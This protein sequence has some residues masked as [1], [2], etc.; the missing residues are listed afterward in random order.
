M[1]IV[2]VEDTRNIEWRANNKGSAL[3]QKM[4]WSEGKGI[5]KRNANTTALRAVKRQE[6]LGLGAKLE[7]EGGQSE[8][9]NTFAAVLKTLQQHHGTNE[10]T[11]KKKNKKE[12][13]KKS[14]REK[15][16]KGMVLPSNKVTAG[17]AQ[18]MRLAKFGEKNVDDLACIFGNKDIAAALRP[19][20]IA[21]VVSAQVSETSSNL[22]SV[23]ETEKKKD[24]K[25]KKRSRESEPREDVH[26]PVERGETVEVERKKRRKDNK[27]EKKAKKKSRA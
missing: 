18:K 15:K 12:E 26:T 2:Q 1:T 6:G 4:G 20:V 14:S 3:L 27:E 16:G 5:G 19:P 24:R 11:K 7:T 13:K 25:D 8:S 10:T 9:T 23:G 17:H 21:P 22:A